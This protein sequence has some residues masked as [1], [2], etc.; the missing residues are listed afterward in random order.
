MRFNIIALIACVLFHYIAQA[1]L[2]ERTVETVT[3]PASVRVPSSQ[4]P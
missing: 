3:T 2:T 4:V 1:T